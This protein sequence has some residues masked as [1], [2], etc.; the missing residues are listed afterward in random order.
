MAGS[1][2]LPLVESGRFAR[3][4]DNTLIQHNSWWPI[5]V[6]IGIAASG[7]RV[8]LG[9]RSEAALPILAC[10]GAGGYFILIATDKA[11]RTLYPL[12]ADGGPD[13]SQPGVVS[14]LGIA[15]YVGIVGAAVALIGVVMMLR[16][17]DAVVTDVSTTVQAPTK[18]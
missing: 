10:L 4:S 16:T 7:Y 1:A 18:K 13:S 17:Q 9:K 3:V 5:V 8:S 12:G 6:A 2:F 14:S 11:S 15:I